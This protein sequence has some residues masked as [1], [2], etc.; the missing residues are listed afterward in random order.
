MLT[1]LAAGIAKYFG[2]DPALVRI[3]LVVL[4]FLTAGLLII[5]YFIIALIVPKEPI[6]TSTK[7]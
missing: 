6:E 3:L 5:I 7:A 1:G 4:E 2:Q